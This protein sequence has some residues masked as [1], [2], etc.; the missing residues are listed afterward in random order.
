M[1]QS[2]RLWPLA[3]HRTL[4]PEGHGVHGRLSMFRFYND[5]L[6]VRQTEPS[7]EP[8]TSDRTV[9]KEEND[10]R[11]C[12]LGQRVCRQ[13]CISI[14]RLM[15]ARARQILISLFSQ[16]DVRSTSAWS[17]HWFR[18]DRQLGGGECSV[19]PL[20]CYPRDRHGTEHEALAAS[21]TQDTLSRRTR[22][23]WK[24]LDV[25][26]LQRQTLCQTDR[27]V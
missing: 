9:Q 6:C 27:T 3:H 22:C 25:S 16:W 10:M 13:P 5:R 11:P 18:S 19:P 17:L 23:P 4:C 8:V 26:I 21:T 14:N 15:W 1:A 2:M 24:T 7:S 12:A 20:P